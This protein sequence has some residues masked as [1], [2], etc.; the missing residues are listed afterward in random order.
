MTVK[1]FKPLRRIR[2]ETTIWDCVPQT[3]TQGTSKGG[4]I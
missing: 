3:E 2:A 4:F 1:G